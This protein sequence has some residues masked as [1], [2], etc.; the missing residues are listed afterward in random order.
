[1]SNNFGDVTVTRCVQN[2]PNCSAFNSDIGQ[3]KRPQ[4]L[5]QAVNKNQPAN[6]QHNL[7]VGAMFSIDLRKVG[8]VTIPCNVPFRAS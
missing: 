8:W 7:C 1:M 6:M 2:H 3:L 4:S 5:T